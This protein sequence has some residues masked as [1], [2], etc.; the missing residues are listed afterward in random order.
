MDISV[1]LQKSSVH[2]ILS[3]S[4]GGMIL[5]ENKIVC[6]V[7]LLAWHLWFYGAGDASITIQA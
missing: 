5:E 2:G 6:G 7:L 3:S 4:S 1:C